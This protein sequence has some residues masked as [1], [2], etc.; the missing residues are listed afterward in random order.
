MKAS[1]LRDE[2]GPVNAAATLL[3][4]HPYAAAAVALGT[5]LL[6]ISRPRTARAVLILSGWGMRYLLRRVDRSQV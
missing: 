2:D 1:L 5:G 4:Q 6:L 3:R